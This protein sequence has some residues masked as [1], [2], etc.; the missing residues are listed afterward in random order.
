MFLYILLFICISISCS[1]IDKNENNLLYFHVQGKDTTYIC[2]LKNVNMN[3]V[4][5]QLSDWVEDFRWIQFENSDTAIIAGQNVYITDNYIGLMDN[6]CFKLFNRN[7]AYIC[8]IGRMGHGPGEYTVLYSA[9]LDEVRNRI[10]AVPFGHK[11]VWV[12]DFQ[13]NSIEDLDFPILAKGVARSM[14]DGSILLTH[15]NFGHSM[16]YFHLDTIGLRTYTSDK[17][18]I[19]VSRNLKGEFIGYN[20]EIHLRNNTDLF[21]FHIYP[22]FADSLFC[23][24]PDTRKSYVRF[25]LSNANTRNLVISETKSAFFIRYFSID[26]NIVEDWK[27]ISD[28]MIA[29]K[30]DNTVCYADVKND[31]MGGIPV[32]SQFAMPQDG[33]YYEVL[34]PI[35]L[36]EMIEE[37]L[38][39]SDCSD[40]NKTFLK[41]LK[42]SFDINGNNILFYGRIK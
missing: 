11:K 5:I 3:P 31:Y 25:T 15:L 28:I 21:T 24:N 38:N 26:T 20:N 14:A 6:Q 36:L 13:G 37:R 23:F 4:R 33:W 18:K 42:K 7:G 8:D 2:N 17:G 19:V 1:C 41:Q 35:Q 40:E 27:P 32:T 39:D 29:S 22:S 9:A 10:Y 34:E 16:Q 30:Y 12:Y